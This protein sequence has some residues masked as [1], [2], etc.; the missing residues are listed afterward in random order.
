MQAP[1]LTDTEAET[2]VEL[3]ESLINQASQPTNA[4]KS[5][6]NITLNDDLE[7][8]EDGEV[9]RYEENLRQEIKEWST[10]WRDSIQQL[11]TFKL[12]PHPIVDMSILSPQNRAYLENAPDLQRFIRESIE[13]RQKAYIFMEKDYAQFQDVLR[14]VL[15]VCEHNAFIKKESKIEE[16]LA[17]KQK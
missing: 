7:N 11:K 3:D 16:N 5:I 9:K 13:F 14:N 2:T 8:Q 6:F 10:L 4:T 1:I 15:E 12:K 17:N